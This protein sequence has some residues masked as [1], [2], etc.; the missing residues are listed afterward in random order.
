MKIKKFTS[1]GYSKAKIDQLIEQ[2]KRQIYL[3]EELKE[4]IEYEHCDYIITKADAT[5]K[6]YMLYKKKGDCL[7][8]IRSGSYGSLANYLKK[9]KIPPDN[10]YRQT[11]W[12][13][14]ISSDKK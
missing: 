12:K 4:S 11:S 9:I 6:G 7:P 3:L 5:N 1:I 14:I 13:H 2:T 10:V 8:L